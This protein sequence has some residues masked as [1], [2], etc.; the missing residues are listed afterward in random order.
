M[1]KSAFLYAVLLIVVIFSLVVGTVFYRPNNPFDAFVKAELLDSS[2]VV[3]K[4]ERLLSAEKLCRKQLRLRYGDDLLSMTVDKH[5]SRFDAQRSLFVV[6]SHASLASDL[7]SE[8]I[9][10]KCHVER[11]GSR[12]D[13]M[14][15]LGANEF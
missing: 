6:F 15:I 11:G 7:G 12:V 1:S 14:D 2:G 10:Y 4:V 5:S 13:Y 8:S 9:Q 3:I